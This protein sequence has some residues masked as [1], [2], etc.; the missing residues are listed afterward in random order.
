MALGGKKHWHLTRD[1]QKYGL[2]ADGECRDCLLHRF[3]KYISAAT[4]AVD[5]AIKSHNLLLLSK[6]G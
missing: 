3:S 1:S 6:R 5:T 2:L 4:S